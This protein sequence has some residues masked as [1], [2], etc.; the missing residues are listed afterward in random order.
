MERYTVKELPALERPYEKLEMYG[1]KALSNAELLAIIIKSGT[2]EETS[3]QLAQRVLNECCREN[4]KFSLKGVSLSSLRDIKGIGRATA[5]TICTEREEFY[6]DLLAVLYEMPNVASSLGMLEAKSIRFT[7][8]RDKELCDYLVSL[9]LDANG[10][11]GVT[12][13][14]D[15]LIVPYEGFTS[16]KTAKAGPNTIIVGI[17]TFKANIDK[18]IS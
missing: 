9:G 8:V 1:E 14:T 6:D 12:K 4:D 5:V 15:I 2:K 3:L 17:D 7:G 18:Y 13:T 10:N 11:G 16:S